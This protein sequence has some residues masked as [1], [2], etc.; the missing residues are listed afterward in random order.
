MN[1]CIVCKGSAFE[2]SPD[3]R[4]SYWWWYTDLF[5]NVIYDCPC[6][7]KQIC[8]NCHFE[9][10]EECTKSCVRDPKIVQGLT[11]SYWEYTTIDGHA[12][13]RRDND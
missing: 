2:K 6:H 10:R 9:H 11:Y 4:I 3:D 1:E 8:P 12:Y 7:D 5:E 13:E